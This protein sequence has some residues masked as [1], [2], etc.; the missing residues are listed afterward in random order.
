MRILFLHM[1]D[2][3]ITE[4]S[5]PILGEKIQ[6]MIKTL[7]SIGS[8]DHCYIVISGDITMSATDKQYE[9]AKGLI[10]YIYKLLK[11]QQNSSKIK[12]V[13]V[14]GNHD[15]D[16]SKSDL[17]RIEYD[18]IFQSNEMHLHVNDELNK[19]SNFYNFS[20][21]FGCFRTP[22]KYLLDKQTELFSGYSIQANLI[23]SAIF[24]T[25]D[26]DKGNHFLPIEICDRISAL[27]KDNIVISV[28]HHSPEW[29]CDAMKIQL[30]RSITEA[31]SI[32]F[33]GHEHSSITKKIG[34]LTNE[35][36]L[37]ITGG[38]FHIDSEPTQSEFSC[39]MFETIS[40]S[41]QLKKFILDSKNQ[42]Y[43]L[44]DTLEGNLPIKDSNPTP[45][46]VNLTY[47]K[48]LLSSE[49]D[50]I[51]A[52]LNEY[53]VFPRL[54]FS[55]TDSSS[56]LPDIKDFENFCAVFEKN[57]FISISG[58]IKS[59]KTA[60]IRYLFNHF[61]KK[62][63]V[64][65]LEG[66]DLSQKK[67][68]NIIRDKFEEA[69][70]KDPI[71]FEKFK[72]LNAKDKMVFIDNADEAKC[73]DLEDV[74]IKLKDEF[75]SI[76][77]TIQD[78]VELDIIKRIKGEL[79]S[80]DS[81]LKLKI[82]PIYHDKRKELIS[83][84][85]GIKK[86]GHDNTLMIDALSTGISNQRY[87]T[88]FDPEFIIKYTDHYCGRTNEII[89]ND[90]AIFSKVF[91]ANLTFVIQT[92]IKSDNKFSIDKTFHL[93]SEIAYTA[94]KSREYPISE[95]TINLAVSNYNDYSGDDVSIRYLL[96]V[97]CKARILY[98]NENSKYV[99]TNYSYFTY[100]I[101]KAI[102]KNLHSHGQ[103]DDIQE[104]IDNSSHKVD[105]DILLF[106]TYL[107]DSAIVL[108][109]LIDS[110]NSF[111][112]DWVSYSVSNNNINYLNGNV[113]N[114]IV[115]PCLE[116]IKK[117]E[118]AIVEEERFSE[119]KRKKRKDA[120]PYESSS[121][122]ND[123][124]LKQFQR[125]IFLLNII[126]RTLPSFEHNLSKVEKK[127]I[128]KVIYE[129]PNKIFYMLTSA[130]DNDLPN[131]IELLKSTPE[132]SY[133]RKEPL[134]DN[135][136][137]KRLQDVSIVLLLELYDLANTYSVKPNTLKFLE[138]KEYYDFSSDLAYRFQHLMML[139]TARKC[140]DFSEE[141]VKVNKLSIK[142]HQRSLICRIA[143]HFLIDCAS[144]ADR[145]QLQRVKNAV[146][147]LDQKDEIKLLQSQRIE[148]SKNKS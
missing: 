101:A 66:T 125:A 127:E 5:R 124:A 83:K 75:G 135:T 68:D 38:C 91:E 119:K 115:P 57:P 50:P 71:A 77:I 121:S 23:N 109:M 95:K 70:T 24:A 117:D 118:D 138:S 147:N 39:L 104:L 88:S 63:T 130:I 8:Y 69:Y 123:E 15:V 21:E 26:S 97:L 47:Q 65:I 41:F 43:K 128:I 54:S 45:F 76:L 146:F 60:L 18:K 34:Y 48:N 29:F 4:D 51:P 20:T 11:E 2:I 67:L 30:D 99:F 25:K 111:T 58:N 78:Q 42:M 120:N 84:V 64:L 1:S 32:V 61:S 139:N 46:K 90:A 100:F 44:K 14:P 28:M 52:M 93:I 86:P 141:V 134:D 10:K 59:G 108:K 40:R 92:A 112:S 33:L 137:V 17:G 148:I 82:E 16:L 80:G 145:S 35:D 114:A 6:Y 56:I 102:V 36:A 144:L 133:R 98:V 72:Q 9:I 3:H 27:G 107:T 37:F 73:I 136:I 129:L 85:V 106:I 122:P 89:E 49:I 143:Y 22:D 7:N 113:F 140:G 126:A 81:Y 116:D 12:I 31:S 110:E 62:K 13:L 96:D 74:L 142:P 131:I 55:E 94:H 105:T 79:N 53:F 19:L 103:S 87:L 132:N